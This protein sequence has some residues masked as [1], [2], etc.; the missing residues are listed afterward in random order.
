MRWVDGTLPPQAPRLDRDPEGS[1]LHLDQHGNATG[2]IRSPWVEVPTAVLSGLGQTGEAFAM[3]FGR[4]E[5]LDDATLST[6]YPRGRSEY[7]EKFEPSLDTTIAAGVI[8]A[9]D[10]VEILELAAASY[11]LIVTGA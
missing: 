11:L 3:L 2:G 7:L 9:E 1:T 6:L 8:L 10:R 4:T 5:P